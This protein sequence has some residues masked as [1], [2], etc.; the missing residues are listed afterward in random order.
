MFGP[1]LEVEMSKK[2]MLLC[3][4]TRFEVKRLK[5]TT[6]LDYMFDMFGPLLDVPPHH[7][8]Y[9]YSYTTQHYTGCTTTTTTTTTTLT[10]PHYIQQWLVR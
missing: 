1:P 9:N 2:C 4:E 10:T 8:H 5:N 6:S 7:L 3:R